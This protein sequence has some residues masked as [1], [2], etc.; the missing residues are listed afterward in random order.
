[1][2]KRTVNNANANSNAL[3]PVTPGN[4]VTLDAIER[5]F[6]DKIEVTYLKSFNGY[7]HYH[8][9]R[10]DQMLPFLEDSDSSTPAEKMRS[11]AKM[12]SESLCNEDGSEFI[13]YERAIKLPPDMLDDIVGDLATAKRR[14]REQEGNA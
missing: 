7:I 12:L 13:S 1:M 9:V 6:K 10:T 4:F 5:Q 11:M 3:P 2:V 14:A 8:P